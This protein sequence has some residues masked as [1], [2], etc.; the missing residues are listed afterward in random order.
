[1]TTI[2]I[3]P[4]QWRGSRPGGSLSRP[5][6]LIIDISFWFSTVA[7][8]LGS[9]VLVFKTSATYFARGSEKS[10]RGMMVKKS[11]KPTL[12]AQ[13]PPQAR[14]GRPSHRRLEDLVLAS[15]SRLICS[16]ICELKN[17]GFSSSRGCRLSF[18]K[19]FSF[20][21]SGLLLVNSRVLVFEGS[22]LLAVEHAVQPS[23]KFFLKG[24]HTRLAAGFVVSSARKTIATLRYRGNNS[25]FLQFHCIASLRFPSSR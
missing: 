18:N 10:P 19:L 17:S 5:P 11:A 22:Q 3:W 4:C 24:F 16:M 21:N 13:M 8:T 6:S 12:K 20:R 7:F 14:R 9:A 23:G 25:E 1:M 2:M 15:V